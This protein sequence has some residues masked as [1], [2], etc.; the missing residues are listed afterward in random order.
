MNELFDRTSAFL[1]KRPGLLPLVGILLVLI[2]FG[3][4]FLAADT[5]WL[6]RTDLLLHLGLIVGLLGLLLIK[7]L[8]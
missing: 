5:S 3:L 7:P 8:Q 4:R 6:V 1:A 2:N